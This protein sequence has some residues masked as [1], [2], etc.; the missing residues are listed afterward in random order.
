MEKVLE[1]ALRLFD[2]IGYSAATIEA[3]RVDSDVSIG[4]IYHY[5]G[6][7]EGIA[8]AL[9]AESLWSSLRGLTQAL[10]RH[11]GGE[12]GVRAGV[13][14]YVHWVNDNP[15]RARFLLRRRE[16]EVTRVN[17]AD[18]ELLNRRVFATIEEWYR[19]LVET[20]ELRELP[21]SLLGAIWFGPAQEYARQELERSERS[22]LLAA[23]TDLADAAWASLRSSR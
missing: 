21:L 15:A 8:G 12:E 4:S 5:F 19:P 22:K 17:Q 1:A 13:G 7:K 10:V 18:V 14:H 2:G 3:I 16:T 9:Y 11:R 23:E 6:S 20:K